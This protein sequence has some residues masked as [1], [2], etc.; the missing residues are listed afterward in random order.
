[1]TYNVR[2]LENGDIEVT[3][4]ITKEELSLAETTGSKAEGF[5]ADL[6]PKAQFL[7]ISF[8]RKTDYCATASNGTR[9]TIWAYGDIHAF[10]IALAKCGGSFSM[11]KGA[12]R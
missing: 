1:M 2:Q 8:G 12:C 7:G 10:A 11:H 4:T 6:G 9:H 3:Q 5:E